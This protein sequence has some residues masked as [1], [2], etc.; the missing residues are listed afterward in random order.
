MEP[1]RGSTLSWRG[2]LTTNTAPP[3]SLRDGASRYE[4]REELGRGG[5]AVVHAAFD[6][7]LQRRVA[8]KLL[9]PERASPGEHARLVQEAQTLAQLRHPNVVIV[10]DIGMLGDRVF[11]AMEL[12]DGESLR[13]WLT[14]ER[15]WQDIV[16]MFAAAGRGLACAHDAGIVH[17]D[18]KPDNVLVDRSG[19]ARVADFGLARLGETSEPT[20]VLVGTL[21]YLAPELLAGMSADAR[22]DQ[23]AFGVALAEA[24]TGKR[25][26]AATDRETLQAAH[27]RGPQLEA[28]ARTHLRAI[29][30]RALALDPAARFASMHELVTALEHDP[31]VR[32][33]RLLIGGGVFAVG[34]I[35]AT[36][37]AAGIRGPAA[38]PSCADPRP[39]DGIWDARAR[40]AWRATIERSK[41]PYARKI[42][43]TVELGLDAYAQA[44]HTSERAACEA[45]SRGAETHELSNARAAC[46]ARARNSLDQLADVLATADDAMIARAPLA[47]AE[48]P[49]LDECADAAELLRADQL[50]RDAVSLGRVMTVRAEIDHATILRYLG[51]HREALAILDRVLPRAGQLGHKPTYAQGLLNAA[52]ASEQIKPPKEGEALLRSTLAA[53]QE[54]HADVTFAVAASGLALNL[55]RLQERYDEADTWLA[56]AASTS[57]RLGKP[58]HVEA[59]VHF[60]AAI[61]ANARK[62]FDEAAREATYALDIAERANFDAMRRG[63]IVNTLGGVAL[64][65]G[66]FEEAGK[67]YARARE[68]ASEVYGEAHPAV[69][70]YDSN[71]ASVVYALGDFPRAV[72]LRKDIVARRIA[73]LGPRA[74]RVADDQMSLAFALDANSEPEAAIASARAGA[75]LLLATKGNTAPGLRGQVY[76]AQILIANGHVDEAETLAKRMVDEIAKLGPSATGDRLAAMVVLADAALARGRTAEAT[77]LL[78]HVTGHGGNEGPIG[79]ALRRQARLARKAGDNARALELARRAQPI[80]ATTIGPGSSDLGV[81]YLEEGLA[82][83]ALRSPEAG[84]KLAAAAKLLKGAR[85]KAYADEAASALATLAPLE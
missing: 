19:S 31:T 71:L 79:D 68:L 22:T 48:L 20:G 70:S 61:L 15:P 27:A 6:R 32:R 34:A 7:E 74:P 46:L 11:L 64:F 33:R 63:E 9:L 25:P 57:A 36:A 45:V 8:L 5:M 66:K 82:Q 38:G 84:A 77:T 59:N 3:T 65:Q 67:H 72:A 2:D 43:T 49:R 55:G 81:A 17:R 52:N 75:E 12:V 30:T 44:L 1:E 29:V 42:G 23:F 85:W 78:A 10:L 51:K 40:V 4:L 62:R 56:L 35:A 54:G 69:I 41:A 14:T 76:L 80:I 50:P 58:P 73:Q 28:I 83:V 13:A 21:P 47:L 18:F 16:R 60:S 26:F 53:A 24:L 39:L 37:V